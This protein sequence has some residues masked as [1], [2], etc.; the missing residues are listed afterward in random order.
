MNKDPSGLGVS[1]FGSSSLQNR[2]RQII[3]TGKKN[4]TDKQLDDLYGQNLKYIKQDPAILLVLLPNL[5]KLLCRISA[6]DT[7]KQFIVPDIGNK[8]KLD[9]TGLKDFVLNIINDNN[10][11]NKSLPKIKEHLLKVMKLKE[12]YFEE[13]RK[14]KLLVELGSHQALIKK[15]EVSNLFACCEEFKEELYAEV[16]M[17]F[18]D[19]VKSHN[20]LKDNFLARFAN[21]CDTGFQPFQWKPETRDMKFTEPNNTPTALETAKKIVLEANTKKKD[22]SDWPTKLQDIKF[23][24]I[25][26]SVIADDIGA[27]NTIFVNEVNKLLKAIRVELTK[28]TQAESDKW[29][30]IIKKIVKKDEYKIPPTTGAPIFKIKDK[31]IIFTGEDVSQLDPA[32]VVVNRF[33]L[34]GRTNK[35]A[36]FKGEYKELKGADIGGDD[37]KI[38]GVT[39]PKND[40]VGTDK[41]IREFVLKSLDTFNK[42]KLGEICKQVDALQAYIT[43]VFNKIKAVGTTNDGTERYIFER[44]DSNDKLK[45]V[46]IQNVLSW[47]NKKHNNKSSEVIK[48]LNTMKTNLV[49]LKTDAQ[50]IDAKYKEFQKVGTKLIDDAIQF[51]E[52]EVLGSDANKNRINLKKELRTKIIDS[53][54]SS[55]NVDQIV[56]PKPGGGTAVQVDA[57]G[58]VFKPDNAKK[59]E[60]G[61]LDDVK[62]KFIQYF[63]N[64][65]G[66]YPYGPKFTNK[67]AVLKV[68]T[69]IKDDHAWSVNLI[70]EPYSNIPEDQRKSD[71]KEVNTEAN[72]VLTALKGNVNTELNNIGT[73]ANIYL[74]K[75]NTKFK[76]F[77]T[78]GISFNPLALD[79]SYELISGKTDM[80]TLAWELL[81]VAGGNEVKE[82]ELLN[83]LN[84][85]LTIDIFDEL[86]RSHPL[87]KIYLDKANKIRIKLHKE[88]DNIIKLKKATR[89][90][91]ITAYSSGSELTKYKYYSNLWVEDFKITG[92]STIDLFK[93]LSSS[94]KKL[95]LFG[96]DLINYAK[97]L[98]ENN[99][100]YPGHKDY[101]Q[102]RETLL[103]MF[104]I[105]DT[106]RDWLIAKLKAT[107]PDCLN[108]K[109]TVAQIIAEAELE[110]AK[111]RAA[112]ISEIQTNGLGKTDQY[113]GK[114]NEHFKKY[115]D[116]NLTY[117][118]FKLDNNKQLIPNTGKS[119]DEIAKD[120]FNNSTNK[121]TLILGLT[122]K[123]QITTIFSGIDQTSKIAKNY[124]AE[125]ERVRK[126]ILEKVIKLNSSKEDKQKAM[127]KFIKTIITRYGKD[128]IL[129]P[130]T[131]TS[132]GEDYKNYK[133]DFIKGCGK[134]LFKAN[135][136]NTGV[137]LNGIDIVLAKSLID[138]VATN[139]TNYNK[140]MK[141]LGRIKFQPLEK[142]CEKN[143]QH[144]HP[145]WYYAWI[146]KLDY[147]NGIYTL[148]R[149]EKISIIKGLNN[150]LEKLRKQIQIQLIQ[151]KIIKR[152]Q[153]IEF[154]IND[155][156]ITKVKPFQTWDGT[157]KFTGFIKTMPHKGDLAMAGFKDA[158]LIL[159]IKGTIDNANKGTIIKNNDLKN[160]EFRTEFPARFDEAKTAL[161]LVNLDSLKFGLDSEEMIINAM[162]GKAPF[163]LNGKPIFEITGNDIKYKKLEKGVIDPLDPTKEKTKVYY[164]YHVPISEIKKMKKAFKKDS[165]LFGKL[166]VVIDKLGDNI[167]EGR[168][169][170]LGKPY[171]DFFELPEDQ[172]LTKVTLKNKYQNASKIVTHLGQAHQPCF[173]AN[174]FGTV[175]NMGFIR[176]K[177]HLVMRMKYQEAQKTVAKQELEKQKGELLGGGMHQL[178]TV[179]TKT[180][181]VKLTTSIKKKLKRL[182]LEKVNENL[183]EFI[184]NKSTGE[185][186][187]YLYLQAYFLINNN[188]NENFKSGLKT[189]HKPDILYEKIKIFNS[190]TVKKNMLLKPSVKTQIDNFDMVKP[191]VIYGLES[192]MESKFLQVE[193]GI[194]WDPE[195][196][197]GL[198]NDKARIINY[199]KIK[200]LI[201]LQKFGKA[202][203][204]YHLTKI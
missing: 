85:G 27:F 169:K 65:N 31:A 125:A 155:S 100:A 76:T 140:L 54:D 36:D 119:L 56:N 163:T 97:A 104:T 165:G 42:N 90:K 105:G 187:T 136:T 134:A 178:F 171:K 1:G 116:T 202:Y 144:K 167:V 164:P 117:N 30:E 15:K 138:K 25:N 156:P 28:L 69:N 11:K 101:L 7:G 2:Y 111:V 173:V 66:L 22:I 87:T 20:Q 96:P 50:L 189:S 166:K 120:M 98:C 91:I 35:L 150:E 88:I 194:A 129:K 162:L 161:G 13:D 128:K 46:T 86:T 185:Y 203:Y 151:R 174:K 14:E 34:P 23:S 84:T 195:K 158:K 192:N 157:T 99:K 18:N 170:A 55:K 182:S 177:V 95:T 113:L 112:M 139:Y 19:F 135:P 176:K 175:N 49:K 64:Q 196:Y 79:G 110:L 53:F 186:D 183:I 3:K 89:K 137:E 153:N 131:S 61:L 51:I 17:I 109:E 67:E 60:L 132:L 39:I 81:K 133:Y 188:Q 114:I 62:T 44:D 149:E 92:H 83:N 102:N 24:D 73:K 94:V 12:F 200:T 52:V 9:L 193:T 180:L 75:I 5:V 8:I 184:D 159:R 122:N 70:N 148:S 6:T 26:T 40:A 115:P 106:E 143:C 199:Y 181:Q 191:S 127:K 71:I 57:Q 107:N 152:I 93:L 72:T 29:L 123:I 38:L 32:K 130:I 147:T 77:I 63:C 160:Y 124:L 43:L 16:E 47:L 58:S 118:P 82:L 154:Q 45:H 179:D 197:N 33:L 172:P 146:F 4:I 142:N 80:K 59:M 10:N 103:K 78:G 126:L 145:D 190:K 201:E 121:N 168:K 21:F 68:F 48:E 37:P 108:I 198:P 41:K 204:T 74:G 141:I